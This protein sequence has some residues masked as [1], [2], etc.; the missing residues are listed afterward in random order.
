MQL[1]RLIL[2][3]NSQIKVYLLYSSSFLFLCYSITYLLKSD[4]IDYFICADGFVIVI[5]CHTLQWSPNRWNISVFTFQF[6]VC[7]FSVCMYSECIFKCYHC[8]S[9][10]SI[11][12][13]VLHVFHHNFSPHTSEST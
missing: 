10:V 13:Q 4:V 6:G 2:K 5:S 3:A 7:I 11:L 12:L 8:G 9:A 1:S